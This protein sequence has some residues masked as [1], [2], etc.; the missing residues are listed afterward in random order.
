[1]TY[2]FKTTDFFLDDATTITQNGDGWMGKIWKVGSWDRA[3]STVHG[4]I[5]GK[6]VGQLSG[7][8]YM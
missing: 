7:R 1:M 3:G 5:L 8:T 4:P 2:T 6:L